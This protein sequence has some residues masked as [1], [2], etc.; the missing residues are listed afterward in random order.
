MY[1]PKRKRLFSLFVDLG[2]LIIVLMWTVSA[3]FS[4]AMSGY[5]T[6]TEGNVFLAVGVLLTSAL[7]ARW[8]FHRTPIPVRLVAVLSIAYVGGV[9]GFNLGKAPMPQKFCPE[10]SEAIEF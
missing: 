6:P 10:R 1:I 7:A 9:I 2:T 4:T 5:D 3:A 8:A